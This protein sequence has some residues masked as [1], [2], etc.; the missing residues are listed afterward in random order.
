MMGKCDPSS[1]KPTMLRPIS[2]PHF[3]KVFCLLFLIMEKSFVPAVPTYLSCRLC[4]TSFVIFEIE[5]VMLHKSIMG[6][7]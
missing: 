6:Q 7:Y 4:A 5:E 3:Q 2:D 1:F